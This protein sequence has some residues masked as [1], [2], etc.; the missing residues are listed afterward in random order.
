MST[1]ELWVMITLA[2]G[3]DDDDEHVDDYHV[4]DGV[5]CERIFRDVNSQR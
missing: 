4:D 3:D 1:M 5:G 2:I